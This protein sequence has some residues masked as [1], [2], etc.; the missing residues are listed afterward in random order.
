MVL[1]DRVFRRLSLSAKLFASYLVI[2]GVGGAAIIAI[3]SYIVSSSVMSEAARTVLHD[4]AV[5]RTFYSQEARLVERTVDAA[6]R[7]PTIALLLEA[8]DTT[9]LLEFLQAVRAQAQIDFLTLAG[10]SGQ[11]LMRTT[12]SHV[13]D[14]DVTGLRP[15]DMV[16]REWRTVAGTE[17]LTTDQLQLENPLLREQTRIPLFEGR[18]TQEPTGAVLDSGLVLMAA[19]PVR[20]ATGRRVGVLYGGR[21]LNRDH[22]MVDD[23]WREL[24]SHESERRGGAVTVTIFLRDVRIATNVRTRTGSRAIGTRVSDEVR[25]GVLDQGQG[26]NAPA[27]VLDT[28]YIT[29]YQP[30]RDVAGSIVGMLYV[31]VPETSYAAVRNR[32]ILSIV[33]ISLLGFLLV[34]WVTYLG[35][36]RL[37]RPLDRIVAATKNIAA[38]EFDHPVEIERGSDGQIDRLA[39]SFNLMLGSLRTMRE[40]LE[41]WG[42]TLEDKVRER[43]DDLVKMQGRVAQSERLASLGL[44]AAGVAHEVNNPLGGILALSALTLEDMPE[45]HP[46]RENLEEVIR[47]AERCR[48]IV[49][50]L[51][52]FSRQTDVTATDVEV[53]VVLEKTLALL[54]RQSLFYNVEVVKDLASDLPCVRADPSGLQQ[55]FMNIFMNA[56]EAMGGEGTLTLRTRSVL[57]T[58]LVEV[59]IRD[60]GCGIAPEHV[61][62][63]FD[64]FFT[65][66]RSGGGTGLGLSIAYGIITKHGGSIE[67]ESEVEKGTMFKVRIPAAAE[68]SRVAPAEKAEPVAL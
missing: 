28:R 4:L 48:D 22:R 36:Q 42:H 65:T 60:T 35:I 67:V 11:A 53:N 32:I 44:L 31:G 56:V 63:I 43:T 2:L 26:W 12:A 30:L 49:K 62:R 33:A 1:S 68:A 57:G 37:T 46:D 20:D 29:A 54:Q 59:R 16:L 58:G 25:R 15:V 18:R 66:W 21:L 24:Y 8:S 34:L 41:D 10:S 5:A 6:A 19:A 27:Y 52:E 17:I 47:Q 40:D 61:D 13:R 7:G 39:D 14:D 51:L 23:V 55:V 64:P 50:D 9:T 45:D 38:G 3:V